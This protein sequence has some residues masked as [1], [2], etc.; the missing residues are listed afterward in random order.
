[1]RDERVEAPVARIPAGLGVGLAISLIATIYLGVLPGRVLEYAY[2]KRARP[3]QVGKQNI[4]A[5][6]AG[7]SVESAHN[8]C[9]HRRLH[10]TA[11]PE[12]LSHS[13]LLTAVCPCSFPPY[14]R[15]TAALRATTRSPIRRECGF[16][17]AAASPSP[18]LRSLLQHPNNAPSVQRALLSCIA[19]GS[20][21]GKRLFNNS[22]RNVRI[23]PHRVGI[24][25][26]SAAKSFRFWNRRA[27]ST[28]GM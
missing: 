23:S 15:L 25:M 14:S 11:P 2:A 24:Q 22:R 4:S 12:Y 17:M 13:C 16:H 26:L 20:A 9:D 19:R 5:N 28:E 1:M 7:R 8:S 3:D 6:S 18:L 21:N 10:D 27:F